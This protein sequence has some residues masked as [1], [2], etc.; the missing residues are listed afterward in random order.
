M[1]LSLNQQ[2]VKAGAKHANRNEK[3]QKKLNGSDCFLTIGLCLRLDS[4]ETALKLQCLF[5]NDGKRRRKTSTSLK[6]SIEDA[7]QLC[8]F[9]SSFAAVQLCFFSS[10]FA[11]QHTRSF[12]PCGHWVWSVIFW[13][14]L[15]VK[16]SY[17]DS[18]RVACCLYMR[19]SQA[20]LKGHTH[21]SHQSHD[22]PVG[23]SFLERQ[24]RRVWEHR[25]SQVCG[26]C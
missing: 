10:S 20:I 13:S 9:S 3:R 14:N 15:L 17:A 8:F 1:S 23:N 26:V 12:G 24:A 11:T 6:T 4:Q 18:L 2:Y 16:K 22:P 7:V 25:K 19:V 21:Q 5:F